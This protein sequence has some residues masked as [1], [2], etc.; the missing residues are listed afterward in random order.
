MFVADHYLGCDDTILL[1]PQNSPVSL[2]EEF[3]HIIDWSFNNELSSQVV[4]WLHYQL[5]GGG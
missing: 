1:V 2:E 3:A 5:V 4:R